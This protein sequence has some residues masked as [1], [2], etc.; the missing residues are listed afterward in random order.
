[1]KLIKDPLR[2]VKRD[3]FAFNANKSDC[4]ALKQLY[5]RWGKCSFYKKQKIKS[6]KNL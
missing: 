4:T 1:M 3:C 6:D 2:T 5:C